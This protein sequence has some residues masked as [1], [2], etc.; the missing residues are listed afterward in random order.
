MIKSQIELVAA[1]VSKAQ[2][3]TTR[4]DSETE[5]VNYLTETRTGTRNIARA[6]FHNITSPVRWS[7]RQL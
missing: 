3:A 4:R 5:T 2:T 7:T 1:F 6:I